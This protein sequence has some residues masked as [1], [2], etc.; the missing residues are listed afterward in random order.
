[1]AKTGIVDGGDIVVF[2]DK[3]GDGTFV[4]IAH[5]ESCKI[6]T[7]TSF[8]ERRTKDTNGKEREADETDTNVS[9]EALTIY[10]SY[11]YFDLKEK[12]LA[13]AKLKLKYAPETEEAGDRYEEGMFFIDSLDRSDKVGEDSKVSVSFVQAA[14]PEIKTV[15]TP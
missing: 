11:S 13:K 12:Q 15:P 6:S 10:G 1:M 7:S 2:I 3:A 8:R 9:V 4:P 14:Q 5:G